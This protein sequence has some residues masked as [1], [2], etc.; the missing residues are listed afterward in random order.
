MGFIF[1]CWKSG[2]IGFELI[3]CFFKVMILF[4]LVC[5]IFKVIYFLLF[6]I[7]VEMIGYVFGYCMI[8]RFRILSF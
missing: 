2:I 7:Y 6:Y 8:S 1:D 3:K 5:K 4:Y